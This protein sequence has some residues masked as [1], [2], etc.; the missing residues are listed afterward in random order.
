[1][2]VKQL[3]EQ[4]DQLFTKRSSFMLMLQEISENFYPER[5]DFT[6]TRDLG[7][8]FAGWLSSSYPVMVRREL[9]D[10]LG[11]MLRPTAKEWFKITPQDDDRSDNESNK[12]LDWAT[13]IQR[14]EMY[15]RGSQ[16]TRATKE[17][18]HDFATFGQCVLS[19][20][21]NKLADGLLYR[22][23]HI[24]DVVWMENEQG[25]IGLV[26]R[27]WKPTARDLPKLFKNVHPNVT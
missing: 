26:G 16:F 27:K 21:M 18:D 3:K 20:E 11:T 14:K 12:W 5:A 10:Q 8:D 2:D 24:R 7:S 6:L 23:W 25:E 9:G 1:M 15:K 22:N 13:R 4:I 17:G 19:V